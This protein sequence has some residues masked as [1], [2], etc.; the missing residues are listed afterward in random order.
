MAAMSARVLKAL[1][2]PLP[3]NRYAETPEF[4]HLAG[5][6]ACGSG[7]AMWEMGSYFEK[8][9]TEQKE[10][11]FPLAAN[12]WRYLACLSEED[13]AKK[14]FNDWENE[15]P[16][17]QLCAVL[18]ESRSGDA[19]DGGLFYCLGFLHFIPGA[20]YDVKPTGNMGVTL[21]CIHPY[22][23]GFFESGLI[24]YTYLDEYLNPLPIESVY[25]HPDSKQD[26]DTLATRLFPLMRKAVKAAHKCN[27][28]TRKNHSFT[29]I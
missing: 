5:R 25:F 19:I 17:E 8:L 26:E 10:S 20:I 24:E 15:H 23:G 2:V 18:D 13:H 4:I 3:D 9:Y 14:W 21:I 6:C 1:S 29:C 7:E 11:F 22:D 12:F 16:G 27:Q 28:E